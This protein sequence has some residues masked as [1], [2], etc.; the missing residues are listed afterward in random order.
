MRTQLVVKEKSYSNGNYTVTAFRHGGTI[1][2]K[3]YHKGKLIDKQQCLTY[4]EAC[5]FAKNYA[6]D[7]NNEI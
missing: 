3:A 4:Q 5:E 7:L 6:D 1:G 2:F